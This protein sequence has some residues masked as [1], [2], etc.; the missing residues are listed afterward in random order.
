[1][2]GKPALL[3]ERV[4]D[5]SNP[6]VVGVREQWPEKDAGESGDGAVRSHTT[7]KITP[8]TLGTIPHPLLFLISGRPKGGVSGAV[9]DRAAISVAVTGTFAL[10]SRC[11]CLR[12]ASTSAAS[13]LAGPGLRALGRHFDRSL[14]S[15]GGRRRTMFG[16]LLPSGSDRLRLSPQVS[17]QQTHPVRQNITWHREV[18]GDIAVTPAVYKSAVHQRAVIWGQISARRLHPTRLHHGRRGSR[19]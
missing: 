18:H 8:D 4:S 7:Q 17:P 3:T 15:K 19:Q 5:V 16:A 11:L 12:P 6:D 14:S 2:T 1:M 13:N 10:H 9:A